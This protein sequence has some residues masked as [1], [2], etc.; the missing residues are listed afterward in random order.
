MF[1]EVGP[2]HYSCLPNR[3]PKLSPRSHGDS[4]GPAM[5]R[6]RRYCPH[7]SLRPAWH[8]SP[9]PGAGRLSSATDRHLC[10]TFLASLVWILLSSL[11]FVVDSHG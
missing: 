3:P 10:L 2:H 6:Q 9:S 5:Q 11:E 7:G 1:P 8:I 4:L